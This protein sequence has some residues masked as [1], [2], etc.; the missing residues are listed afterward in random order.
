MLAYNEQSSIATALQSVLRQSIF[1]VP[2]MAALALDHVE[3]VCV[4]NGCTDTTATIARE[5][6]AAQSLSA[7]V[8]ASV[9]EL[10]QGGKARTWNAFVHDISDP[11][12]D[13]LVLVDS[14]ITI[15]DVSVMQQLVS[16]LLDNPEV[17]VATDGPIKVFPRHGIL[18][19]VI[20]GVSRRISG[21]RAGNRHAICGQLYCAR[22]IELR[23]VW[24]PPALP[25]EDG[26]LNAIVQTDGFTQA[27]DN[28][29]VLRVEGASHFFEAE[30][31][32]GGYFRH[33]TR[34]LVGSVIN[35][36]LFNL[37]WE[38]GKGG[39]VGAR[40]AEW[41]RADPRWLERYIDRKGYR[42]RNWVV[43]RPFMLWRLTPLR[44]LPRSRVLVKLPLAL[45]ATALNLIACARANH[46]LRMEGGTSLW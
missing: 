2:T 18:A 1:T 32:L 33:E 36:W 45:A 34:I 7:A 23:K 20:N 38:E 11:T 41:N 19:A 31:G 8:T 6:I 13:F 26:F 35:A 27:A 44:G 12:A 10:E 29:T 9:I 25:V 40:I 42:A 37:L 14:D 15:D 5:T 22:A 3:L 21:H 43:P 17:K 16:C 28:R 4:P 24:M 39:H 30:Q 46:I